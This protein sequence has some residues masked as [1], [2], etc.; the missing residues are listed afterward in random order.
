[1]QCIAFSGMIIGFG[2]GARR[3]TGID[4]WIGILGIAVC[5]VFAIVSFLQLALAL[6]MIARK[7]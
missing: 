2:I 3:W 7:R 4:I 6:R 5:A 1:M